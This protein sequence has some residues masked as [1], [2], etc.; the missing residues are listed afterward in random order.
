MAV[1]P[2]P[3]VVEQLAALPRGDEPG[4]KW[5]TEAQW[6][7][8]LRFLGQAELRE[9]TVA[10]ESVRAEATVAR[11]GPRIEVLGSVV[12]VPVTGL[13][14]VAGEVAGSMEGVGTHVE[15]RPFHGHLTLARLRGR[16]R[17]SLVG[18]EVS[19]EFPVSRLDLVASETHHEGSRYTTRASVGLAGPGVG[20]MTPG[21]SVP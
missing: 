14:T 5:T 16:V 9:A 10:L 13:E 15:P 17:C 12:I 8:T 11:L 7:I 2:P 21:P 3:P 18:T 19:G 4:V 1:W 20:G 6:H